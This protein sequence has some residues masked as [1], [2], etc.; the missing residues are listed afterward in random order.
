MSRRH[1]FYLLLLLLISPSS[2][3]QD[4]EPRRWS[5]L[6]VGLNVFGLATGWIEGD[7]FLDPVL[8][9]ED[10]TFEM[11]ATG[12]VYVRSFD[13]WGKSSRID[14]TAPYSSG[15]WEGY[16]DGQYESIRRRGFQDPRV[17]FSV[18][19]Y[20]APALKAREFIQYKQENPINTTIGAAVS[21]TLP[22]GDYNPT[23]LINLGGNRVV[24]RPQLGVLHQRR[25]WQ[26]ELTGSVFLYD[27][28]D[29]FWNGNKLEQEPLWFSQGHVIYSIRP[30]WWASASAG[31]GHGAEAE[32][33]GI[34]KD[35]TQNIRFLALSLG[36]PVNRNQSLKFT[37]LGKKTHSSTGTDFGSLFLSWSINWGQ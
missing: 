1:L 8:Q 37:W 31:F 10:V 15:R 29:K 13:L 11:W 36:M 3:A 14:F 16:V 19:L 27:G 26:F 32:V 6:P 2:W 24:I 22:W 18:N 23:K 9:A 17:R 34:K 4:L 12:F 25:N 28:N 35:N 30:G 20:G 5:H 7:I 33:N 21:I